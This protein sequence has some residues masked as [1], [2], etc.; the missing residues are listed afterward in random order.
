MGSLQAHIGSNIFYCY[1]Y[2]T[3]LTA[4]RIY[5]YICVYLRWA[6]TYSSCAH[7]LQVIVLKALCSGLV[8][9]FR[10]DKHHRI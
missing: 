10:F 3:N 5:I 9:I 7:T 2:L 8:I 1:Y 4:A 6:H